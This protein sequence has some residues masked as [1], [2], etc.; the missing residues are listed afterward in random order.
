MPE[1]PRPFNV[2]FSWPLRIMM[3]SMVPLLLFLLLPSLGPQ[4]HRFSP[5]MQSMSKMRQIVV[6][7]IAYELDH[8]RWPD[9]IDE[10]VPDYFP[11]QAALQEAMANPR[12][13]F[14]TY[15]W[16]AP[17]APFDE[18]E[19]PSEVVVLR[20]VCAHGG[21]VRDGLAAFADGHASI[22]DGWHPDH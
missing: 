8:G 2:R 20:E 12:E 5:E 10:L 13:G 17:P 11:D 19:N 1:Q 15:H 14:T 21:T 6:M 9:T 4:D 7:A 18:L 3:W 16:E 22:S